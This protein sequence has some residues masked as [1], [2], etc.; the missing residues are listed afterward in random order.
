MPLVAGGPNTK[1]G[2][3]TNADRNVVDWSNNPI[4]RLYSAGEMS[5]CFKWVYQSGG[6]ITEGLVC[7]Q[8]AG[9]NV[10]AEEPWSE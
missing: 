2:L 9:E 6:N 1:G 10:A 5:S 3:L 7:G 4:P 8:I